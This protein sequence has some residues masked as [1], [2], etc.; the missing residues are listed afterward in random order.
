MN[1]R[2]AD[3][4]WSVLVRMSGVQDLNQPLSQEL[5]REPDSMLVSMETMMIVLDGAVLALSPLEI[6]SQ[7]LSFE[8]VQQKQRPKWMSQA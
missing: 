4:S 8:Y 5:L 3:Q 7:M 2:A 6:Y 1:L